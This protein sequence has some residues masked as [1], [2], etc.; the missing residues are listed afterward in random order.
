MTVSRL[1]AVGSLFFL[2]ALVSLSARPP[3]S[4]DPLE[5]LIGEQ[6][7]PTEEWEDGHGEL[8]PAL[9]SGDRTGAELQSDSIRRMDG[10][11]L[12]EPMAFDE[13]VLLSRGDPAALVTHLNTDLPRVR[14]ILEQACLV[15]PGDELLAVGPGEQQIRAIAGFTV[16]SEPVRCPTDSPYSLWAEFDAPLPFDPLFLTADTAMESGVN[17]YEPP[18][19]HT[20]ESLRRAIRT[21]I[22]FVDDFEL[23]GATVTSDLI[24]VHARRREIRYEDRNLPNQVLLSVGP[25]GADTVWIERVDPEHGTGQFS[26]LGLFDFNR[27]GFPD[28]HVAGTHQECL[29]DVFFEGSLDGFRPVPTPRKPCRC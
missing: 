12:C 15:R 19:F 22:S 10:L 26:V 27:D 25:A 7:V 13:L 23:H 24:L 4:S 29:Y 28:L 8:P 16:R 6:R 2:S 5:R 20:A 18:E 21:E 11:A 17:G 1:A 14:K 9:L 3:E